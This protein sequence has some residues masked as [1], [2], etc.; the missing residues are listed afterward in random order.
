MNLSIVKIT[1]TIKSNS[2]ESKGYNGTNNKTSI[3]R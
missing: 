1:I 2:Q 3:K